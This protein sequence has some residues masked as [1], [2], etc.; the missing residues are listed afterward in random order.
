MS[1]PANLCC[2]LFPFRLSSYLN[3]NCPIISSKG[4]PPP[5]ALRCLTFGRTPPWDVFFFLACAI[6]PSPSLS[7]SVPL[8]ATW[9]VPCHEELVLGWCFENT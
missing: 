8:L 5:L 3:L 9:N 1:T 4:F 6:S 7:C 2:L